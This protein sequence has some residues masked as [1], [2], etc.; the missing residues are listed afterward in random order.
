MQNAKNAK[1]SYQIELPMVSLA[2][3]EWGVE[4]GKPL[5]ALHGWLDNMA[6][7]YP[8]ATESDWLINNDI[9]FI[10]VDWPGHGHSG[11][12]H[13]GHYYLLDYVQDLYD[14][15]EA[16]QLDTVDILAH[17]LGGSIATL[18]AGAFPHKVDHLLLIESLGPLTQTEEQGPSQLAKSISLTNRYHN[19]EDV[20]YENL[21]LVIKARKKLTDLSAE[22]VALLVERN[23]L[24]TPKG[25]K[26]RSDRRLRLPSPL[27]LTSGQV[28]AFINNLTMPVLLLHGKEGFIGKYPQLSERIASNPHI[29][30][31]ELPGGH[32]LH[33][34]YPTRV[35]DVLLDFINSK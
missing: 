15:I 16:L 6:S 20:F 28:Q 1:K 33:M 24:K 12:R 35:I 18:F 5:I 32:H 11:H 21:D 8:L 29:K 30:T 7:F 14:F 4:T 13:S 23:M 26:W 9:R 31:K 19:R 17:S 34:Q 3:T 27:M 25:L 2:V 10:T 22:H